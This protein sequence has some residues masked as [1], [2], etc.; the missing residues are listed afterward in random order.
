M[1][2]AQ[3]MRFTSVYIL[4]FFSGQQGI[5]ILTNQKS[6]LR[7]VTVLLTFGDVV[8]LTNKLLELYVFDLSLASNITRK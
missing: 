4:M 7:H 2:S 6:Y 3:L 8:I 5:T 1:A